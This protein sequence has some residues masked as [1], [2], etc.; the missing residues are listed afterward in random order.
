MVA[1]KR[2]APMSRYAHGSRS[3]GGPLEKRESGSG[4]KEIA[5]PR[6]QVHPVSD[7]R[8]PFI[9]QSPS[10]RPPAR[11]HGNVFRAQ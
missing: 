11:P 2:E 6:L 9:G 8:W 5:E 7:K 3:V 1:G 10:I 4:T